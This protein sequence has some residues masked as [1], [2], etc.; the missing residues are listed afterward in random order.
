MTWRV[1]SS[2]SAFRHRLMSCKDD[3]KIRMSPCEHLT[4][5]S[6]QKGKRRLSQAKNP[7]VLMSR[8]LPGQAHALGLSPGYPPSGQT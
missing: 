2:S 1:P 8:D 4:P 5:P 3:T 6:I 7:Q